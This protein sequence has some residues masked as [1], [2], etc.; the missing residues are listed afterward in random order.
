MHWI[1]SF[2]FFLYGL[3]PGYLWE[4]EGK[5]FFAIAPTCVEHHSTWDKI[6]LNPIG[7]SLGSQN[8]V[9]VFE[10]MMEPIFWLCWCLAMM[11]FYIVYTIYNVLL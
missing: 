11:D 7:L 5:A 8:L 1:H 3:G 9:W 4:P 10:Y 6:D 2:I